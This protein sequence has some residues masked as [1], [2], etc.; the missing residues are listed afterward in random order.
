MDLL[1]AQAAGL[2]PEQLEHLAAGAAGAV[3][4]AGQLPPRVLGPGVAMRTS[5]VTR[6]VFSIVGSRCAVASSCPLAAAA[7][8]VLSRRCGSDGPATTVGPWSSRPPRRPPT[9][10]ARWRASGRGSRGVL[11][12][13]S[14]PHDYEVRP[15]DVKALARASL[16]VRSGGDLDEWLGGAIDSAGADAPG[17]RSDRRR[18]GGGRGP[19]LVA[20]PAARGARGPGDRRRRWRRPIRRARPP[21]RRARAARCAGCARS[22]P[23]CARCL[24][25]DPAGRAHARDDARRARLLRPP[26]RPRASS[27]P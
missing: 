7:V 11:A 22:T 14:D 2:A 19:A 3:P 4:G 20:G 18:R 9:S 10:R 1:R 27:A 8:A 5:M 21:T 23:R 17:P 16:V 15:G 12:P 25:A 26:L 24:G 13:N 6:I